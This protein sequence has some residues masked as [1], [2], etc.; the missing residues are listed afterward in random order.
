M[1]DMGQVVGALLS[2]IAALEAFLELDS[3]AYMAT[4]ALEEIAYRLSEMS[5]EERRNFGAAISRIA[6]AYDLE[7]PGTGEWVR[8]VPRNLGLA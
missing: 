8:N 1:S 7:E 6:A 4:N 2:A 5:D 3:Q